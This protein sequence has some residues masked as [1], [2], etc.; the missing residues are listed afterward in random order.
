MATQETRTAFVTGGTGFVGI[1]IVDKLLE[2]GWSVTA[3][4]R[5]G[6]DTRELTK[7]GVALAVGDITDPAS[8]K[9]AIPKDV[10]AVFHAAAS[11]SLWSRKNAERNNFV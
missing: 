5:A 4:H 10:D 2:D 11:L 6:A 9:Q 8:L 7:R 1:N 3:L